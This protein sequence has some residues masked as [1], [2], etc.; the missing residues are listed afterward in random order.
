MKEPCGSLDVRRARWAVWIRGWIFCRS[1]VLWTADSEGKGSVYG[2]GDGGSGRLKRSAAKRRVSG[3]AEYDRL[4][5][6]ASWW[7]VDSEVETARWML[8]WEE[9]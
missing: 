4:V 7:M 6:S 3:S 8:G 2:N 9:V 1:A 5:S